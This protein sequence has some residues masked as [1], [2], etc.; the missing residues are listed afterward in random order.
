MGLMDGQS[1]YAVLW[2][3]K[4]IILASIV[5]AVGIAVL[6]TVSS[7]KTYQASGLLRV[8]S[9]QTAQTDP[10]A[11][12]GVQQANQGLASS[13][14]T[15]LKSPGLLARI[16][17]QVAGG[18]LSLTQL[19]SRVDAGVVQV[20][21]QPT[22]LVKLTTTGRSPA[23][24]RSL[25]RDVAN[26]FVDVIQKDA[27][28]RIDEQ[29]SAI[30]SQ[31]S[32]LTD[33]IQAARTRGA[34]GAE[35]IGPLVAARKGLT[36]QEATLI[37]NGIA[38]SRPV[39]AAADPT[40]SSNAISPRPVLNAVVALLLGLVVGIGLAWLRERLDVGLH[41]SDEAETVLEAPK[42]ATIPIL[43]GAA[44]ANADGTLTGEAYDVLRTNLVFLGVDRSLQV[45]T[46]TSPN[47]G[48]GKS[49]VVAGLARAAQRA[50]SKVLMVDCDL[51]TGS[52]SRRLLGRADKPGLT[53]LVVGGGTRASARSPN[54]SF[55]IAN[56]VVNFGEGL[57]LLPAGP[58]PPNPTG[59][60]SSNALADLMARLRDSYDLVLIDSPPVVNLA[61]AS[62]L[63]SLSDGVVLVARVGLTRRKDLQTAADGLRHSPTGIVGAVVFERQSA[64]TAYYPYPARERARKSRS[65]SA[66]S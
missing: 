20:N 16:R 38:S 22:N 66:V 42:L 54:G 23:A 14:A 57:S 55:N 9:F 17:S 11:V 26:A 58:L 31:I 6:I 7:P 27:N 46:F 2:R 45:L 44:K 60:L 48:E 35:E 3:R 30:E 29:K 8:E 39:S 28:Q 65:A 24:A 49:S 43:K 40:A 61:D 33:R 4:W 37:A 36:S 51:R 50:G 13:F 21:N 34:N 41:D 63:A 1:S 53:N 18:H 25:A 5:F 10:T 64:A 12:S 62:L 32:S 52:L 56:T 19:E 15:L 59:L 47:P